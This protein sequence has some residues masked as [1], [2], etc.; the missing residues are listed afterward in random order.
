MKTWIFFLAAFGAALLPAQGQ[1][2]SSPAMAGMA[3]DGNSVV[4]AL[5][6]TV[7]R[8]RVAARCESI[9]KGPYARFAQKYLGVVAP[10]SDKDI[11][12]VTGGSI[13][14]FEEGDP[15]RVF[16]L[17]NPDKSPFQL[18][19]ARADGLRSLSG[20]GFSEL[21]DRFDRRSETSRP[22][23]EGRIETVSNVSS[24]TSF[25]RMPFDKTQA[26]ERSLEEQA[27]DAANMIFRLRKARI[28]LVTGEAGENVFGGGLKAALD[29]IGR[30]EEEYLA[31]FV[32]KSFVK[33]VV[34]EFDMIPQADKTTAIVCRFSSE[35]GLLPAND[36]SGNPIV[37]E[38]TPENRTRN[39]Q[40]VRKSS[41]PAKGAIAYPVADIV[42]CRLTDGAKEFAVARIPVYQFGTVVDIPVAAVK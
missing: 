23:G 36:L 27:A 16:V 26:A 7:L 33:E 9:R 14:A 38:L 37:L 42:G 8:I 28:E 19:G 35:K 20:D 5:P 41:S 32:G 6:Q 39:Q 2:K 24:D 15:S 18:Y 4:Y 29:E 31:L 21:P 10:L 30:L 13:A 17:D 1:V 34:R 22:N 25:L 12:T 40:V 3:V 11:Y